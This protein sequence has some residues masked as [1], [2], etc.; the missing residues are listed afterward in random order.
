M[1]KSLYPVGFEPTTSWLQGVLSSVQD[2]LQRLNNLIIA[3]IVLLIEL[4]SML[5]F[6]FSLVNIWKLSTT[7]AAKIQLNENTNF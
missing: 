1:G 3:I 4:A 2:P 6:C 5:L 7:N